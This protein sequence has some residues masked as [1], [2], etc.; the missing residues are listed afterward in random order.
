MKYYL[1]LLQIFPR[2]QL[3]ENYLRLRGAF[4]GPAQQA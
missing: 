2:V 1:E 3:E 4:A